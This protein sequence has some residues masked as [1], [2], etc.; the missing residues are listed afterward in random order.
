MLSKEPRTIPENNINSNDENC[1][2][3]ICLLPT[4]TINKDN[5]NHP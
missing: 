5:Q 3:S 1:Y 4:K 2:K